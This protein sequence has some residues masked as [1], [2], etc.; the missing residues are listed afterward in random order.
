LVDAT[1]F[2]D[3]S[4]RGDPV[5]RHVVRLG[6]QLSDELA[7]ESEGPPRDRGTEARQEPIVV[8]GT[9]AE[10]MASEVEGQPR[11]ERP[12]DLG[13]IDLGAGAKRLGDPHRAGAEVDRGIS[14]E[15]EPELTL[16]AIDPGANDLLVKSS[17]CFNSGEVSSSS[18][19]ALT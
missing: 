14:N 16:P 5:D 19:N 10:A 7:V 17:A 3:P 2:D 12:V 15:V 13:W 1:A 11:D 8:S 4:R 6:G 9:T 18:A